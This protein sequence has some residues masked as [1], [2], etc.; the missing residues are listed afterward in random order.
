[1]TRRLWLK[2]WRN[3]RVAIEAS[4]WLLLNRLHGR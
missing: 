2:F 4:V 1:M 3:L